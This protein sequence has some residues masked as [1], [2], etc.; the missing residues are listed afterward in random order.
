MDVPVL[1]GLAWGFLAA[2]VQYLHLGRSVEGALQLEGQDS[3]TR[4]SRTLVGSLI[5]LLTLTCLFLTAWKSEWIRLDMSVVA[6]AVFHLF[7]MLK[8]GFH[9]RSRLTPP[10]GSDKT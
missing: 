10:N 8:L 2:T 4:L 9:I 6:F 3:A 5:R 7:F 1:I